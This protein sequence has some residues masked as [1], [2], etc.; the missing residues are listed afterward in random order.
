MKRI[1]HYP[2]SLTLLI[3]GLILFGC[4][5]EGEEK[6]IPVTPD[7][8]METSM[9]TM[10]IRLYD[11]TPLHRDNFL[12]LVEEN[13]YDSII[14]HRV[15]ENFMVQGGDPTTR[16]SYIEDSLDQ[17]TPIKIPAEFHP[18]LFHKRGAL[19]AAR[20]GNPAR[21]SSPTQFY[22]VQGKFH[23]DSIIAV[24]ESRINGWLAMNTVVNSPSGKELYDLR[25]ELYEQDGDSLKIQEI[26][27]RL[28][29]LAKEE[30]ETMTLYQ[31][32]EDQRAV[33]KSIGGAAHLDQNYTVFG[34]VIEGLDV[35]DRIGA[36]ATDERDRPMENIKILGLKLV[37]RKAE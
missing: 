32:P 31:I 4:S 7:I 1:S 23:N 37:D 15:I 13:F 30:E 22:I 20:D 9:G 8:A 2:S 6:S 17:E 28:N 29:S 24:Q 26:S 14:F 11:E 35:I 36:T 34:E 33:Y 3:L 12:K 25:M 19:G 5:K 10:I 21:A 16:P 27:A 18:K